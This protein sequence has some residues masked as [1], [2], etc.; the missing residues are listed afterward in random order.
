MRRSCAKASRSS[1]YVI[2]RGACAFPRAGQRRGI[3]GRSRSSGAATFSARCRCS[4]AIRA[5]R[6]CSPKRTP[7]WS[8]SDARVSA[9]RRSN[10]A[11]SSRSARS[12]C[13]DVRTAGAPPRRAGEP[14][15]RARLQ[16]A[17]AAAT[18]SNFLRALRHSAGAECPR[19]AFV[20]D[21]P[22][23]VLTPVLARNLSGERRACITYKGFHQLARGVILLSDAAYAGP[24]LVR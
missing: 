9:D 5:R 4:P 10:P 11:V 18:N 6:R 12:R 22:S 16:R 17:A 3:A 1:F 7:P 20:R 2:E 19:P 23:R 8:K 21:L 13:Q 14:R 24:V 15:E